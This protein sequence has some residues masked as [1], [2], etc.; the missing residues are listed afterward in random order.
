MLT[1]LELM[2]FFSGKT[3]NRVLKE[4]LIGPDYT[5]NLSNKL[6][7]E[8]SIVTHCLKKLDKNG[9]TDTYWVKK[10]KYYELRSK[11]QIKAIFRLLEEIKNGSKRT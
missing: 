4:L 3:C 7:L 10:I 2:K 11:D 9:L 8:S 5:T 1:E 6:K